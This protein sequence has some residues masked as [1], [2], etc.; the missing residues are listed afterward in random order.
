MKVHEDLMMTVKEIG[1]QLKSN[2]ALQEPE[3]EAH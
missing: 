1:E 3:Y 2:V